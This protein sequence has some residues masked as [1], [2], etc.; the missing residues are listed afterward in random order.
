MSYMK[1]SEIVRRLV[2]TSGSNLSWRWWP[3]HLSRSIVV[4]A[5]LVVLMPA[6]A[7]IQP[8][9]T[10]TYDN[11]FAAGLVLDGQ[12]NI[13][14]LVDSSGDFA[15]LKYSPDGTLL[16]KDTYDSSLQDNLTA[17]AADAAGQVWV[18]GI[19]S[20]QGPP[21]NLVTIKYAASGA[22]LWVR[23]RCRH[24]EK[25]RFIVCRDQI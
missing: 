9:W 14:L 13:C 20:T 22:R 5:P 7:Q 15:T 24:F 16:W 6:A 10:R 21:G 23:L 1:L 11:G 12:S 19:S 4:A 2:A 18:T 8:D 17:L 25:Q 3:W